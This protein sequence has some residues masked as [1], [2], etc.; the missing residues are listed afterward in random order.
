MN[1]QAGNTLV[2]YLFKKFS[3]DD[4]YPEI[5][6]NEKLHI[7][8]EDVGFRKGGRFIYDLLSSIEPTATSNILR[9]LKVEQ[10]REESNQQMEGIDATW[11]Q[12]TN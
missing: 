8:H 4:P 12:H 6:D 1:T 9:D 11:G 7:Y 2:K 5:I 3:L 10:I